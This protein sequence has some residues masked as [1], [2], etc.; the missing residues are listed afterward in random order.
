M[1]LLSGPM[2]LFSAKVRVA[3][4]EK[5][6]AYERV[7]VPFSRARGYDPK[8]PE[9]LALNP[10]GQ[11]PV[12]VDDDVAIYDSMLILEYIEER[13]PEPRLFPSDVAGRARCRQAEAAADEILFPH[14]WTLIR[15]SFYKGG[16]AAA[17]TAAR[18][19]IATLCRELDADLA[20][21]TYLCGD[22]F[23]VADIAYF[24]TL[25]FAT[26]LGAA[27]D[28][29][30]GNVGAWMARV[31]SRPSMQTETQRLTTAAAAA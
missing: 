28:A 22:Q 26:G 25:A 6:V 4:D 31:A 12:L 20:G 9:V 2:S 14:V 1:K 29:S 27:P 8:H 10:K 23:T 19:A 15:E 13:Y 17:I 18:A 24:L 7:D 11:V 3:L 5:G 21:R 30:L 16:D